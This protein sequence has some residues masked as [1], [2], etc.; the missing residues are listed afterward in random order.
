MVSTGSTSYL[1]TQFPAYLFQTIA[2]GYLGTSSQVY[3]HNKRR[4]IGYA[5]LLTGIVINRL[6]Y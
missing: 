5:S 3:S 2:R 1:T 4:Y 6:G